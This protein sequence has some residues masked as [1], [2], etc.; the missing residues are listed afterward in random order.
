MKQKYFDHLAQREEIEGDIMLA[1]D[2]IARQEALLVNVQFFSTSI[3]VSGQ[4]FSTTIYSTQPSNTTALCKGHMP[5]TLD[6]KIAYAEEMQEH[7]EDWQ[8]F[9][10]Q[11]E[12][13]LED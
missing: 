5:D 13:L 8:R 7:Q 1:I 12:R 2:T 9:I 6:E 10:T 4:Y 11:V 3:E